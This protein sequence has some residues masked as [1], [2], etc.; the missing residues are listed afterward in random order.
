MALEAIQ[1]IKKQYNVWAKYVELFSQQ[2]NRQKQDYRLKEDEKALECLDQEIPSLYKAI[3]FEFL[4][5]PISGD[6]DA[7]I[8]L[9]LNNPGVAEIDPY[10]YCNVGQKTKQQVKND[11]QKRNINV[12]FNIKVKNEKSKLEE[13]RNILLQQYYLNSGTS[14]YALVPSFNTIELTSNGD[15]KGPL[16]KCGSFLWFKALFAKEDIDVARRVA[17]KVFNLEFFPYHTKSFQTRKYIDFERKHKESDG[18]LFAHSLLRDELIKAFAEDNRIFIVR[19]RLIREYLIKD[20]NICECKIAYFKNPR[21]AS[22]SAR[23]LDGPQ[24]CLDKLFKLLEL[25]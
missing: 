10:N 13:R 5:D 22:L 16:P 11:L 14:P 6:I 3:K 18:I 8:C 4:P 20:L 23:N 1:Q 9:I 15:R 2:I 21:R 7:P 24:N 17:Q 25:D 19:S 12:K